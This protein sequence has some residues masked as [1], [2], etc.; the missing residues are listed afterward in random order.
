MR[1]I[2]AARSG[3]RRSVRAGFL[4]LGCAGGLSP[5]QAR[6]DLEGAIGLQAVRGP[7]Y[8][9]SARTDAGL[10][11]G[12]YVRWRNL[13]ISS[14]G[15]FITRRNEDVPRGLGVALK[16]SPDWQIDLGLRLDGGRSD[17]DDP[18]LSGLGGVPRTV[19]GRL[20]VRWRGLDPWRLGATWSFDALGRG[21]GA[22]IETGIERRW[23]PMPDAWLT[24]GLSTS[25]A[26]SRHHQ[27]WSGVSAAQ[28][29]RSGYPVYTPGWG[30]RDA[31]IYTHWRQVLTDR[32]VVGAGLSMTT[33]LGPAADS[34]LVRERTAWRADAGIAWRF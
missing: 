3:V 13:T 1:L 20:G 26:S 11:V 31:S 24:A 23:S 25:L 28:A 10:R 2:L 18:A 14:G 8:A 7:T 34:P 22:V 15:G 5:I 21:G 4:L 33:L 27:T 32:W 17:S 12:G 6:E 9:G 19:R 30:W 29:V 16:P